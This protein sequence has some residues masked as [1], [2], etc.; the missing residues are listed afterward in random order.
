MKYA[1]DVVGDLNN[2]AAGWI[3]WNVLLDGAG[4]PTCI[5]PSV[6]SAR[7]PDPTA[8]AWLPQNRTF[9]ACDAPLRAVALAAPGGQGTG[10]AAALVE[11]HVGVQYYMVGHFSRFLPPGSVVLAASFSNPPATNPSAQASQ[12]DQSRGSAGGSSGETNI[13]A[14]AGTP[15]PQ[16]LAAVVAATPGGGWAAVV[17]NTRDEA[18]TVHVE[19][20]DVPALA[21]LVATLELPANAIAT[22]LIP[23]AGA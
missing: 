5:G 11:L 7:G 22:L 23:P 4:G 10:G 1:V 8:C 19:F 9:G 13:H 21:G 6:E 18:V 12:A 20:A 2:W 14:G 16:A 15:N 3:E 17:L